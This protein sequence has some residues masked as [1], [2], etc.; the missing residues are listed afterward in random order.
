MGT[1][2]RQFQIFIV[3]PVLEFMSNDKRNFTGIAAE[4][5]I[6]GTM[7]TE[8]LGDYVDQITGPGDETL[9]PAVGFFQMEKATHDDIWVNWLHARPEIADKL[10]KLRAPWNT[11][12]EQMAGNVYYAVAMCRLKYYRAP[13]KLPNPDDLEDIANYWKRWYNSHLGAGTIG[14][15]CMKA[16]DIMELK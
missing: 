13:E 9:G 12:F 14:Q 16:H 7:L 10:Y 4:R 8:S 15:F 1:Q 6:I 5:L 11:P 2:A 3:R